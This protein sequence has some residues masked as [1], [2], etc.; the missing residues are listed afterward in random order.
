MTDTSGLQAVFE[1]GGFAVTA[2]IGPP[3]STDTSHVTRCADE[4]KGLV[5]AVNVTDNPTSIV[6]MSSIAASC[7]GAAA[8]R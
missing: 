1:A 7:L 2:E 4:L 3:M 5:S 8:R 6:R